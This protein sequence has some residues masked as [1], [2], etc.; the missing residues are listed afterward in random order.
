MPS[1]RSDA[2]APNTRQQSLLDEVRARGAVSVERLA[3]RLDVT[4][5]TVRRD[6]QRLTEAGL[7][8]RFHGGVSLPAPVAPGRSSVSPTMAWR[9]RQALKADAKAR[10]A[11]SVAAAIPDGSRVMLGIGTTVEA[12]A[13][14]LQGK[15]KLHIITHSLPVALTL[16]N[17]PDC[18]IEVPAGRLRKRDGALE[19]SVTEQAL[20][21]CEADI[22]IISALGIDVQGQLL[23]RD[24]RER[25]NLHA[26]LDRAREHW[27]VAD[28]SKFSQL[29][30][31]P[32]L[33]LKD[34]H[35]VFTDAL[36]PTPLPALMHELGISLTIAS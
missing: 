10:I 25:D 14:A 2:W 4:M 1:P 16:A 22:V 29:P 32:V 33:H 31:T 9:E 26:M 28:T 5:Q 19:G 34:I 30:P 27:L 23:D 7:L 6:I 21:Q 12:V 18:V 11:R 13:Q 36:P 8:D 15:K 20:R 35:R 3:Q 24:S 17:N